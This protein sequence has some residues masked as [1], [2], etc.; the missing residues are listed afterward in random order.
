MRGRVAVLML[1][2]VLGACGTDQVDLPPASIVLPD[3]SAGPP[4]SDP[5]AVFEGRL[6]DATMREGAL[7][8]TI[9]AA[10]AGN[11]AD[12]RLAVLQMRQWVDGERAWLKDHPVQPCYDA[13]GTK[14]EAALDSIAASADGFSGVADASFA[15]SDEVSL[16]SAGTAG[17]SALQDAAR[18]LVDAAALAKT[19]RTSCR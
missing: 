17:A 9:A 18:A 2:A 6:R 4:T 11:R 14:F 8:R 1:G 16:Q 3:A 7:V 13:A 19:A 15:P 10:S 12:L 5:L